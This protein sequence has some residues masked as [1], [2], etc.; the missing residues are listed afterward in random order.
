MDAPMKYIPSSLRY[1]DYTELQPIDGMRVI[2]H[3]PNV[4]P[5][6]TGQSFY[7]MRFAISDVKISPEML[8]IDDDLRSWKLEDRNCYLPGEKTLKLFKIYS[9]DNCKQECLSFQI[10]KDCG[11]IPFYMISKDVFFLKNLF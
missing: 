6:S 10:L 1:N 7:Q 9:R 4:Y 2:I 3:N 5:L 8:T 11:C